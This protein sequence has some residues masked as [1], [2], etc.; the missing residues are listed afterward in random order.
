MPKYILQKLLISF[1]YS[2]RM[3][4]II[5][6]LFNFSVF[7]YAKCVGFPLGNMSTVKTSRL[8]NVK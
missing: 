1:C 7:F 8:Q 3:T 5:V 2:K 6:G 4:I